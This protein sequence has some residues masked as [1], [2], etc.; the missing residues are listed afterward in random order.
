M[1]LVKK[2]RCPHCFYSDSLIA[3]LK[4]PSSHPSTVV[5]STPPLKTLKVG[6]WL[7]LQRTAT[8][9]ALS[10]LHFR[11]TTPFFLNLGSF[12]K[13]LKSGAAFLQGPHLN[14][15]I[16]NNIYTAKNITHTEQNEHGT[17][18]DEC[19]VFMAHK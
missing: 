7:I 5:T 13:L 16:D 9:A 6:I 17:F 8:L 2:K 3:L 15:R 11:N 4:A 12:A 14:V 19:I 1:R 18:Q 10:I